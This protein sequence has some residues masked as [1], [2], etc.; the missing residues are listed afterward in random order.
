LLNKST[1]LI[2]ELFDYYVS[3][4]L[5]SYG[6]PYLTYAKFFSSTIKIFS[7]QRLAQQSAPP[8]RGEIGPHAYAYLLTKS[9][10]PKH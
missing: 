2:N 1:K 7:R 9:S 8:L 3:N 10:N 5:I 4:Y 6:S